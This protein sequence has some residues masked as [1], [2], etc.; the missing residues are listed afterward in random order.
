MVMQM[1]EVCGHCGKKI[2][3]G[4]IVKGEKT[5]CCSD[6]SNTDKGEGRKPTVCEFC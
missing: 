4:K 6:C 5:Y 1:D 2:E 3:K